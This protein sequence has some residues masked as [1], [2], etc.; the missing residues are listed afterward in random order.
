MEAYMQ[1][2][3]TKWM[4]SLY[5]KQSTEESQS[6]LNLDNKCILFKWSTYTSQWYWQDEH[7]CSPFK[8]EDF[9]SGKHRRKLRCM[10]CTNLR[11]SL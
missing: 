5:S 8:T 10:T 4:V 2:N 7:I 1:T 6:N 9:L 3:S 11:F